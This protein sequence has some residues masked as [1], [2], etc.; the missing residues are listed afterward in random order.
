MQFVL[1]LRNEKALIM[2]VGSIAHNEFA[3]LRWPPK[4]NYLLTEMCQAAIAKPMLAA[5]L[6]HNTIKNERIRCKKIGF[7]FSTTGRN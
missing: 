3:A 7:S 4:K 1:I 2:Q 5:G 6:S